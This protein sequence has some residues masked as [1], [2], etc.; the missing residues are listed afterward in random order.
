MAGPHVGQ[1]NNTIPMK[2]L[3]TIIAFT[4]SFVPHVQSVDEWVPTGRPG[5]QMKQETAQEMLS[6]AVEMAIMRKDIDLLRKLRGM[7]WDPK[8]PLVG[9]TLTGD[10]WPALHA[11]ALLRSPKVIE[12]LITEVGVK[13]DQR[14]Q[15][16]RYAITWDSSNPDEISKEVI[17]LLKRDDDGGI[18]GLYDAVLD[19]IGPFKDDVNRRI[20]IDATDTP[21]PEKFLKRLQT[22]CKTAETVKDRKNIL[23]QLENGIDGLELITISIKKVGD[24]KYTYSF[25]QYSGPLSGGGHNGKVE[26]KY[27]YWIAEME[28]GFDS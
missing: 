25:T 26:S 13:K 10:G 24:A 8:K 16:N 6:G 4:F 9:K 20:I 2:S 15:Y 7:G 5:E 1:K 21:N 19:E 17:E 14:G 18:E 3:L 28:G 22:R 11:A 12:W 27:G 23:N